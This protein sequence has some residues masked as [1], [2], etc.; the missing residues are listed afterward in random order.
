MVVKSE[1][2]AGFGNQVHE[3]RAPK[4]TRPRIRE[5]E[6]FVDSARTDT[7]EVT[8][9]HRGDSVSLDPVFLEALGVIARALEAGE[10]VAVVTGPQDRVISS[11]EAADILNVSRPH[12]VKLAKDRVLPHRKVGNRHRFLLSEVVAY[13]RLESARRNEDLASIAPAEGYSDDD[14]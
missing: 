5:V 10:R 3:F 1:F 7:D 11:Q 8:V 13:D 14:F 2:A 4:K 6:S 12:V 9:V